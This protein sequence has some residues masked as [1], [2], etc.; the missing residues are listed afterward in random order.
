MNKK[1]LLCAISL[2]ICLPIFSQNIMESSDILV[3]KAFLKDDVEMAKENAEKL[4]KKNK[5]N[6]DLIAA[7]GTVFLDA[8]KTDE[9]TYFF[10]RAQRCF[11]ISTKAL[12]L[13]GDIARAKNLP[14]SALY[15]YGRA[16][17][18]DRRDPDAYYKYA[19]LVQKTDIAKAIEKLR[20]LGQNRPDINIDKKVAELYYT[21]NDIDNALATYEKIGADS[22]D[23]EELTHYALFEFLKKDYVKTLEL[24]EL[25]HQREPRNVVFNRLLLYANTEINDFEAAQ[26]NAN[27]L[28]YNSDET[29]LQYRDY[30]YYGYVLNGLGKRKEA[31]D[32][33]NIALQKNPD[34]PTIKKE[35]AESYAHINDYDNAIKYYEAY[36]KSLDKEDKNMAYELFQ[37]GRL[38]WRKAT[39]NMEEGKPLTLE[40]SD[41]LVQ[42]NR[43][44]GEIVALRPDTYLGYYW[45]AKVNGLLDQGD[46]KGL[47][48]PY[49]LKAAEL[50]EQSGE[51]QPVLIECYKQLSFYYYTRKD[52]KMASSYA[53]KIQALNPSD[54]YAKQIIDAFG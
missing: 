50:L 41:A 34:L 39:D 5:D 45:Q 23:I 15:Y 30:I 51:S 36:V 3:I 33:F 52:Y 44:Y 32:Q 48:K 40:Q 20:V 7:V 2:L 49:F 27:D 54:E 53:H 12:N 18:F 14:D 16:M 42:A 29:K 35:I 6:T 25:G 31:I 22:L 24:A 47:S 38:Y 26:K 11:R 4:I 21:A 37:L 17:Y 43:I 8:G 46:K 19:D 28:L 1:W 9:A 10:N 13:G